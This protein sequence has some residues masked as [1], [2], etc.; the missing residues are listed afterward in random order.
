MRQA[1]EL[2]ITFSHSHR[3]YLGKQLEKE[4]EASPMSGGAGSTTI[5]G[6]A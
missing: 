4:H 1:I 2:T 6:K 3:E 5:Q